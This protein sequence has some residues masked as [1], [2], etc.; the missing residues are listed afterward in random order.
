MGVSHGDI[1]A[2]VCRAARVRES[3][4][5]ASKATGPPPTK[6]T[7]AHDDSSLRSSSHVRG[8]LGSVQLS[9]RALLTASLHEPGAVVRVPVLRSGDSDR[10]DEVVAVV[11]LRLT[12]PCFQ[13]YAAE[14]VAAPLAQSSQDSAAS[15]AVGD[16]LPSWLRLGD[17]VQQKLLTRPDCVAFVRYYE[18]RLAAEMRRRRPAQLRTFYYDFYERHVAAGVWPVS[19]PRWLA[20][21]QSLPEVRSEAG[22]APTARAGQVRTV[23]GPPHIP[24]QITDYA[25]ALLNK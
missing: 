25:R 22:K 5:A 13:T 11:R 4:G 17:A 9:M 14:E 2:H 6:P 3:A 7:T 23:A 16:A 15:A 20:Q 24:S 1:P 8:E 19:L 12:Q 10:G 18:A 21:I